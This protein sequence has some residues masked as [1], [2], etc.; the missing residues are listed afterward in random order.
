MNWKGVFCLL[1]LLA[2]GYFWPKSVVGG[3]PETKDITVVGLKC[4]YAVDPI[5]LDA[6]TPQFSWKIESEKRGVL[7]SVYRIVIAESKEKLAAGEYLWDSGEVSASASAGVPYGGPELRSRARYYWQVRVWTSD[8][9]ESEWSDP[10]YF[11]MGLLNE[12]DW[13]SDWIAYVPGMPGRVLYFKGTIPQPAEVAQARLYISGLGFYEMMI[14][15]RKVGNRVLEPAQ[16]TYNKRIYYSTYDVTEYLHT[17]VNVLLATV[18]P[19]WYG[20][21]KLRLQLEVIDKN[22]NLEVWTSNNV[23]SVTTGPTVYS[24]IFDGEC[25]DARQD[26]PALYEPGVP[27]GLMN[28]SWGWAHVADAPGGRMVSQMMEPIEVVDSLVPQLIGE[29]LPGVYVFDTKQ[30]L[31]GWASLRV[32][33]ERGR[34]V[35]MKFAES[36]YDDGTINQENLRNAKAT[37]TYILKGEGIERWEPRFTYHGFRY[38][39]VEGLPKAPQEGD[40]VVKIVRNAV[41]KTGEFRCSNELLNRIHKMVVATESSN[42]H[43]VPTD[44][45]QRDERMGWMNDLTVR[46]E[47][48]LYNFDLSRFYP[49]FLDDVSDTQDEAGTIT[50]VAPY[51]FGARPADPVSASYLLLAWK[52]YEYYGNFNV[53]RDHYDGMKAWVDYLA[54]RTKD[55]VVEYSYYGDWSPPIEFA[56]APESAVSKDTPGILMSTGYLYYCAS[57]LSEMAALLDN[58]TDSEYYRQLAERTARAFNDTWWNEE[59]GGYA[60]NNQAANS[61]ALFLGIV[62]ED[63]IARVVDN[64][65]KDV[66]AHDYHLTTGNLCT[67]YLMEMLTRYGHVETAYKIAVQTTYPSWG[68]M[69]ENGA[70]TLWER[71][72]Y[73]TGDAMNSHNHPMMGSVDSWFYK[74]ILGIIPDVAHP[75]FERFTIHPY[76]P[77]DLEFAEGEFQSVKGPVRSA[78]SK[79]NGRLTLRIHV[80]ANSVATVYVPTQQV[81]SVKESGRRIGNSEQIRFVKEEAGCAVYEVGS[82]DYS[83]ESVWK[84]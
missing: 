17:G 79:Q 42:L 25:Y 38:I 39:Q 75:G 22:G 26:V 10:A 61:F 68:Y 18:A 70:T 4:E 1:V 84:D 76:I 31:A 37:D 74:Y 83:F 73:A 41:N 14:N 8:G 50:C 78:W 45:P 63:R 52:C 81:R 72:E 62:P 66:A 36:L 53:V 58:A 9:T 5:G 64:L 77:N 7:Q 82:G 67:K 65:A 15:G 23:R 11:E 3:T 32:E 29:P 34:Q 57:M 19:G 46:I 44:C 55:G 60:A 59:K 71:W 54:S 12:S 43:S 21:S 69:L 2:A 28:Q 16:S 40:I 80:P 47:Q 20:M 49:K 13:S 30:N 33:G 35:T 24:T 56:V 51:R 48:A 6:R 27:A